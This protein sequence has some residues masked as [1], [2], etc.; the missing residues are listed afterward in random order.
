MSRIINDVESGFGSGVKL[1]ERGV[2]SGARSGQSAFRRGYSATKGYAN[3]TWSAFKWCPPLVIYA[4]IAL[5]GLIG[6]LTKTNVKPVDRFKQVLI[7]LLWA[8][9]WS[10][11]MYSFC[12]HG[13]VGMAWFVLLLP[14]VIWVLLTV[15]IMTGM[16]KSNGKCEWQTVGGNVCMNAPSKRDC[17]MMNGRYTADEFCIANLN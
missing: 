9:F 3:D 17:D 8:I 14:I 5:V 13:S 7:G 12:D 11:V 15:M 10:Y 16:M 1:L 6:I 2:E 4:I